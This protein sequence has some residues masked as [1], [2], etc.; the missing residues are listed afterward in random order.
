VPTFEFAQVVGG[1]LRGFLYFLTGGAIMK[2][3]KLL[4]ALALL[5]I[6]SIA[7]DIKRLSDDWYLAEKVLK[8]VDDKG[9]TVEKPFWFLMERV[10][11]EDEKKAL[12]AFIKKQKEIAQEL[13]DKV[14]NSARYWDSFS[15]WGQE[16][17]PEKDSE[18]GEYLDYL[19]KNFGVLDIAGFGGKPA[20]MLLK[21]LRYFKKSDFWVASVWDKKP[22]PNQPPKEM[23]DLLNT[24]R[25]MVSVTTHPEVPFQMHMGIFANPV[26]VRDQKARP[27][28]LSIELHAFAAK[29]MKMHD[30][31]KMYM[32]TA[33]L[34]VMLEI[35]K[36]KLGKDCIV[37]A[38]VPDSVRESER[39]SVSPITIKRGTIDSGV[40]SFIL[41][42]PGDRGTIIFQTKFP[43]TLV[44]HGWFFEHVGQSDE[45]APY[46]T[47][48]LDKLAK[49]F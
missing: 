15:H 45:Y 9:K 30:S 10:K 41:T 35:L 42:S 31:E 29:A 2:I 7:T 6:L 33:P 18:S 17:K 44:K 25:M 39:T 22:D 4:F 43:E 49:R 34:P 23:G 28:D 24:A 1:L 11:T 27:K 20:D 8:V 48:E 47:I 5:P 21:C 12:E 36:K 40:E 46:V 16:K 38:R 37:G 14:H 26:V 32:I 19:R 3:F 13:N